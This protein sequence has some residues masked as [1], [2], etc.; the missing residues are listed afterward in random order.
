MEIPPGLDTK[1]NIGPKENLTTSATAV[2]SATP[3]VPPIARPVVLPAVSATPGSASSTISTAATVVPSNVSGISH[4]IIAPQ[5]IPATTMPL[6][7]N[8]SPAP[9]VPQV[10]RPTGVQSVASVPV[11]PPGQVPSNLLAL[12]QGQHSSSVPP[13]IAGLHSQVTCA[14]AVCRTSI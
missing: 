11:R 9:P 4:A 7:Q 1:S 13:R 8:L 12:A 6:S 5:S 3:C 10:Q 2:V 14:S